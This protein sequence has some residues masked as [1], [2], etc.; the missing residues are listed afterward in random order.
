MDKERG[1]RVTEREREKR[2]RKKEDRVEGS[3]AVLS[4]LVCPG[5]QTRFPVGTRPVCSSRVLP[6]S[7]RPFWSKSTAASSACKSTPLSTVA[8]QINTK[9]FHKQW[10]GLIPVLHIAIFTIASTSTVLHTTLRLRELFML[11]RADAQLCC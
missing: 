11:A 8:R 3:R 1:E 2:K 4:F 7:F 5:T 10:T 9:A 6:S